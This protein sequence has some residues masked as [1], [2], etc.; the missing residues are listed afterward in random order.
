MDVGFR[1]VTVHEDA[2]CRVSRDSVWAWE[3]WVR[4]RGGGPMAGP[5]VP[6]RPWCAVTKAH[7]H[8]QAS[9][10]KGSA[11]IPH[12]SMPHFHVLHAT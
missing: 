1:R 3:V 7:P 8:L 4:E 6:A 12:I 2:T 10:E 11:P 5:C 9:A